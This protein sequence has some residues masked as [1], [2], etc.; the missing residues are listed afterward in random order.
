VSRAAGGGDELLVA[1]D[2]LSILHAAEVF[3]TL[4]RGGTGYGRIVIE[5]GYK[6][7]V[8]ALDVES[9]LFDILLE[10]VDEVL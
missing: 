8:V 7:A 3:G 5:T 9:V 2:S 1:T 6:G 10:A 4:E